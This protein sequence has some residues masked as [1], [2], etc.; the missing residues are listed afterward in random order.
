MAKNLKQRKSVETLRRK[1]IRISG[2][3]VLLQE[4]N[5][6]SFGKIFSKDPY[7]CGTP[8]CPLCSFGKVFHPKR[9][10]L[11]RRREERTSI[12]ELRQGELR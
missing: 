3:D 7:D 11:L 5:P 6:L 12:L 9:E 4:P 8:R 10:R 1:W 2:K